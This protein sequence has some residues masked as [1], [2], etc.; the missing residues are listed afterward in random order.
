MRAHRRPDVIDPIK[1]L[2]PYRI[3]LSPF[4]P[5]LDEEGLRERIRAWIEEGGIWLAGPMTDNRNRYA[6]K[7][8]H[9][10]FGSL[11]EWSGARW[12]YEIPGHPREFAVRWEDGHAA[13][14][15]IWYDAYEP[16]E[17][18]VLAEYV[19]G[20][21]TGK[22]AVL[23]RRIGKG[24]LI[25]LGTMPDGQ[26]LARLV[27]RLCGEAGLPA[28][29]SATPNVLVTPREGNGQS[30]FVAVEYEN[31]PGRVHLDRPGVD[32]LT[33]ERTEGWIEMPAYGVVV[34]RWD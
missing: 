24:S 32:L 10:P 31:T 13:D 30:G 15:S 34:V 28:P 20:P 16:G 19:E 3:V 27:N 18:E 4:L 7:F 23:R 25:L 9:S 5:C 6:A 12:L 29:P 8:T 22:A 1:D 26:R 14:G 11:E 2:A 33:G 21:M 17:A